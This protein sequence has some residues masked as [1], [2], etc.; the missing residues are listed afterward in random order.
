MSS[1]DLLPS[2]LAGEA[3][4]LDTLRSLVELESPSHDAQAADRVADA[5]VALLTRDGWSV[6]RS[7]R[8]DVGD[9]VIGRLEGDD[10]N[11]GT[12]IL[13]HYDTV[14]PLG[15]LAEMPWSRDG[16]VARGPGVLDM[17][18]GIAN[19]V[20]AARAARAAGS[21]RGPVTLL[22]S[23]DEETGSLHSRAAIE[24]EAVR[25]ARVLVVEPGR[26]D[27]ALKVGRKGVGD[28]TV[29]FTG[30]SAHAGLNP[31]QGASALREMARFLLAAEALAD[32][33][34]GTTVNVTVASG[35]SAGNVIAESATARVDLRFATMDESR[36][37]LSELHA[38]RPYDDRVRVE[39]VGGLNRPPMEPTPGNGA[40]L[41]EARAHARTLGLAFG[42]AVVGGGSDGNFTSA[43]GVPTLD[44]LGAIGGGPHA[45]NEH[46]RIRET[47]ERTALVASLLRGPH[48]DDASGTPT[49]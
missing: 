10:P 2:V 32:V 26:D 15:T 40:L 23:S 17:K 25:H 29:R 28:M 31:E 46:V 9:V 24:A 42:E 41:D 19:A 44:G 6:E 21:L 18:A 1:P 35:G 5:L 49:S 7:P 14:W 22:V 43:L 3:A 30:R 45:R 48:Q 4:F 36:R 16:D 34:N 12:L 38:Y 33:P 39:M 27:G 37:V 20:H 13:A 11:D 47:L 8:D